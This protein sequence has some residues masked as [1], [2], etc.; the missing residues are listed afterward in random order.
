MKDDPKFVDKATIEPDPDNDFD[1]NAIRV[2]I[3]YGT[4]F[5]HVGFRAEELTKYACFLIYFLLSAW[6]NI[7]TRQLFNERSLIQRPNGFHYKVTL[8]D[9]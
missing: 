6:R 3:D 1:V 5:K 9:E 2:L 4:G 8:P 7:L